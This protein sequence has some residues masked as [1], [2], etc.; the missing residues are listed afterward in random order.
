MAS[1]GVNIAIIENGKVLLTQREDFEYWVLPGGGVEPGETVA[2]AARREAQEETGLEVELTRL[3]GLYYRPATPPWGGHVALFAARPVGGELQP[4]PSEVANEAYFDA[5]AIPA[6][7]MPWMPRRIQDAL[8]G[9]G[10]SLTWRLDRLWPFSAELSNTDVY[11]FR[12]RSGLSKTEFY[13]QQVAQPGLLGDIRETPGD[14]QSAPPSSDAPVE[15]KPP[16][17]AANVAIIQDGRVLLLQRED[18]EVWGLPGGMVEDDESLADAARREVLEEVGLQVELTRLVGVYSDVN[19]FHRGVHGILFAGRIV[20]GELRVDPREGLQARF[21]DPGELPA[22]LQFGTRRRVEDTFGGAGGSRVWRQ[23]IAWP[24]PAGLGRRELY[25]LRDQS[26]LGR[27]GFFRVYM[28]KA[29]VL[30]EK[31]EVV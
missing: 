24:F 1:L 27:A 6:D 12:D 14:G 4:Q 26:G 5:A 18:Y 7:H 10:G 3:V 22:D 29:G 20:G 21:F 25:A 30:M 28:E 15:G 9:V 17:L 16:S 11:A 8:D 2:Q 13:R 31:L 19:L 23:E